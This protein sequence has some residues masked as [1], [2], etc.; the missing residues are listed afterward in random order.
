MSLNQRKQSENQIKFIARENSD[1]SSSSRYWSVNN[2][3]TNN[4]KANELREILLR[5]SD[6]Y[7]NDE[8]SKSRFTTLCEYACQL[9]IEKEIEE[10]LS[11]YLEQKVSDLYSRLFS[12]S[13]L[14]DLLGL[15]KK[16]E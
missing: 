7:A 6:L 11:V 1:N 15:S 4:L 14:I 8:I 12:E 9:Y 3:N 5:L 2:A 10:R 13:V 16:F